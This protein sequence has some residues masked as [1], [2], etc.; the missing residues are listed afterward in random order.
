[1]AKYRKNRE[2]AEARI[3]RVNAE[4][5]DKAEDF[6]NAIS[7]ITKM[8]TEDELVAFHKDISIQILGD[9][10]M[11]TP[12]AEINGGRAR[13]GWQT[14]I[15]GVSDTANTKLD[16]NGSQTEERGIRGADKIKPFGRFF[17]YNAV[18]YIAFLEDG[19]STQNSHMVKKAIDRAKREHVP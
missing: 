5:H 16:K 17:V 18:H 13:G 9:V 4:I 6:S 15:H 3:A 12:V 8:M 1:M 10:I 2:K 19:H 7:R 14:S 11:S